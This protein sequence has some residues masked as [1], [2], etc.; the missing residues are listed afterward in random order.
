MR[1]YIFIIAGLLLMI[2]CDQQQESNNDWTKYRL[3]GKVKSFREIKFLAVDRFTEIINGERVKHDYNKEFLFNL[4]GLI[5]E[6]NEYIPDGTLENRTMYLYQNNELIE[7]NDY[8][9]QGMLFGTGKYKKDKSGQV[10]RLNYKT[11]DGR[12]NWSETYK[13][14][15]HNR[16]LEIN[17]LNREN[18]IDQKQKYIYDENGNIKESELYR[19]DKLVSKNIYNYN[20]DGSNVEL[21]YGDSITY[22]HIYS[23]D[24]KGNWIKKIVFENKNP[25]GILIREIEYF[26]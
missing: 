18:V 26:D 16:P 12:Y 22:T 10:T 9:S 1:R 20:E 5:I 2:S 24:S 14:D 3:K 23:F 8:D 15:H 4:D 25:S 13:F 11:T 21:N 17:R 19:D 7:Y 6:K